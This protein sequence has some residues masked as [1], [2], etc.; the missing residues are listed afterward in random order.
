MKWKVEEVA[1]E[2]LAITPF[3]ILGIVYCVESNF[4]CYL[5]NVWNYIFLTPILN[6]CSGVISVRIIYVSVPLSFSA[7]I[8]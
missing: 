7:G 4:Y 3:L 5:H 2:T 6:K 1:C 8:R